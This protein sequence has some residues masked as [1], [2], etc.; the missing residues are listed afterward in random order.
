MKRHKSVDWQ[1]N[2]NGSS[3]DR[4]QCL[5]FCPNVIGFT[6]WNFTYLLTRKLIS[7]AAVRAKSDFFY[8]SLYYKGSMPQFMPNCQKV[9]I[10]HEGQCEQGKLMYGTPAPR[11]MASQHLRTF[12]TGYLRG[13]YYLQVLYLHLLTSFC[14]IQWETVSGQIGSYTRKHCWLCL[15]KTMS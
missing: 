8:I 15:T 3:E 5:S 10:L 1:I 2:L 4:G 12:E 9:H 13:V 11:G 6:W 7:P 14:F